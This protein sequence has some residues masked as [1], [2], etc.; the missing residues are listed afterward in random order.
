MRRVANASRTTL[1]RLQWIRDRLSVKRNTRKAKEKKK[2]KQEREA[3]A[4][5]RHSDP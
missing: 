5:R 3:I 1:S 4:N 2:T